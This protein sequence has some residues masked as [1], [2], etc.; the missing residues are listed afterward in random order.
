MKVLQA[1]DG[2]EA[3]R[4]WH[5]AGPDLVIADIHMPKKS[6]LLLIQDLQAHSSSTRV[7]VMTDGGPARKFNLLGLAEVLGAART[8]TKPFTLDEMMEAVNQELSR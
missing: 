1:R 3:T 4:L 2:D 7:I 8:I 6:G 5:E